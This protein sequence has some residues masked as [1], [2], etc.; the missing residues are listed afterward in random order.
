MGRDV[1]SGSERTE[2][3]VEREALRL[4]EDPDESAED[5][6]EELDV[7]HPRVGEDLPLALRGAEGGWG[8]GF[9]LG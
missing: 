9:T 5:D 1:G 8:S 4:P 2:R 6:E 3:V 7:E